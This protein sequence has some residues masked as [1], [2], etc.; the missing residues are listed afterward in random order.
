MADYTERLNSV[1]SNFTLAVHTL[2]FGLAIFFLFFWPQMR[3]KVSLDLS[4]FW[5]VYCQ[6]KV[7]IKLEK[8]VKF[9]HAIFVKS[10]RMIV[11]C[12]LKNLQK[13]SLKTILVGFDE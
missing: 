9:A 8:F 5:W 3:Q 4:K 11:D 1:N 10:K 7:R 2:K 13:K 6:S 12:K